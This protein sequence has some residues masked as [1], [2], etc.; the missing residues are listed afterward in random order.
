MKLAPLYLF[1]V[2]E[3]GGRYEGRLQTL[4]SL[5]YPLKSEEIVFGTCGEARLGRP[6]LKPK[7]SGRAKNKAEGV[8]PARKVSA[9]TV[10]SIPDIVVLV[11]R[12]LRRAD[13]SQSSEAE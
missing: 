4:F 11:A 13:S 12:L 1:I 10:W 7:M 8:K 5:S 9:I 6:T 2:F 3:L